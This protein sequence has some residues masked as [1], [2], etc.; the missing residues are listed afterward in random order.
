MNPSNN[1]G[2]TLSE[3]KPT[4][5]HREPKTRGKT[6]NFITLSNECMQDSRLS[7]KARGLLAFV[8]S[9]PVIFR[10]SNDRL[11]SRTK[12][13]RDAVRAALN[14]LKVLGYYRKETTRRPDGKIVSSI[15]FYEKPIDTYRATDFPPL[16]NQASAGED[17]VA[18]LT[19]SQ[20]SKEIRSK[21]N[22]EKIQNKED[23]IYIQSSSSN[24][25]ADEDEA[26]I[27]PAKKKFE[28][29]FYGKE[30]TVRLTKKETNLLKE[31]RDLIESLNSADWQILREYYKEPKTITF[32]RKSL[33]TAIE[34]F[35]EELDRARSF[36]Q[37]R[38]VRGEFDDAF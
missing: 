21:K 24:F 7:F 36:K 15:H 30:Q 14:E 2:S 1:R 23:A 26:W 3:Q 19:V 37:E 29:A 35:K 34:N 11:A 5:I 32:A 20:A 16:D 18:C 25:Q 8:L 28:E 17:T 22:R 27:P 12:E 13:G 9:G 6:K 31:N 4:L 10:W 38:P 33:T